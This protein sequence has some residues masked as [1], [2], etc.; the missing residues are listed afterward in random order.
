MCSDS[1]YQ[2]IVCV[3]V[4]GKYLTASLAGRGSSTSH[5]CMP[6]HYIDCISPGCSV[7]ESVRYS[8]SA[9]S[10]SFMS[11]LTEIPFRCDNVLSQAQL[12]DLKAMQPF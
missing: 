6:M 7:I 2:L 1:E 11:H 5:L 3:I 4:V 10:S 9:I 12:H 8:C